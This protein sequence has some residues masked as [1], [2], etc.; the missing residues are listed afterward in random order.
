MRNLFD[1]VPA[2]RQG[3]HA[4][5][6]GALASI[7]AASITPGDAILVKGSLGSGMKRVIE[8]I[9]AVSSPPSTVTAGA[10]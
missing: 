4:A 5:D 9:E 8:A 7:V 1:A 3:A 6:S 10:G 2:G